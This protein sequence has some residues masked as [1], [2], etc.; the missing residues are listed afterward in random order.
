[1]QVKRIPIYYSGT[2]DLTAALLLAWL[3]TDR[4]LK[5]ALEKT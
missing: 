3:K 2:G 5:S 1:M 4:N